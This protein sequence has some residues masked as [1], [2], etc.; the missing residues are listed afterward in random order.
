MK[1]KHTPGIWTIEQNTDHYPFII[2]K[3]NNTIAMLFEYNVGLPYG[4]RTLEEIKAN[5]NLIATAPE[6]L[7]A[8]TNII[9]IG[10]RDL[11]NSKYDSYFESAKR[12]IKKATKQTQL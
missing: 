7:E 2:E 6:L 3:D 1:T 4:N 5:A 9:E 8:L 12:V 11:S 10:K